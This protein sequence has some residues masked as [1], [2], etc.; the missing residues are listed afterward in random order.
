MSWVGILHGAQ[1][2]RK[3]AH[4]INESEPAW[5]GAVE[6]GNE[7]L[8][9]KGTPYTIYST[10]TDTKPP[11]HD[12]VDAWRDN[13]KLG[14]L[15]LGWLVFKQSNSF[16][17]LIIDEGD[18]RNDRKNLSDISFFFWNTCSSSAKIGCQKEDLVLGVTFIAR[19]L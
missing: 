10:H 12:S 9:T 4:L 6:G 2:V 13:R 16:C 18:E 7:F 1:G 14:I 3:M 19:I 17:G 15:W 8:E 5:M 11:S